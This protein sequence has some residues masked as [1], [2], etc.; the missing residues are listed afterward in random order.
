MQPRGGAWQG[1]EYQRKFDELA[2]SGADV[3][4]EADFVMRFSPSTVLDA[5]CGTGRVATEL[6]RRGVTVVGVDLDHSML[7]TARARSSD[8]EWI[9]HDVAT[10]D[11]GR[12]FDVVVLAG[13]VPLFT[14]D[15]RLLLEGCARHVACGGV[16]IAGFSLD[17]GYSVGAFDDDCT[18]A[19][20]RLVDRYGTWDG[21]PFGDGDYA[22]SVL[23]S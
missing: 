14:P 1:N 11:L 18:A 12:D 13:N 22:V 23:R 15:P 9:E 7:E 4:G 8:I 20:L 21:A 17:R 2:A 10:L 6:A 16:L 5:G 3:H 19:G